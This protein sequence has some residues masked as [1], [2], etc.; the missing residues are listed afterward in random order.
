MK[1]INTSYQVSLSDFRRA[2]YFGLFQRLR[3]PLQIM[4]VVLLVGTL[5]FFGACLGLGQINPLV[6]FITAA[7]L[8][9]GI[10]LFAGTERGVR[11]YLSSKDCLIGCTYQV[12]LESNRIRV[13]VPQRNI[14]FATQVNKLTCV[15]ETS[16]A[17]L[18]Y[19]S[20][21]DVHIL[22]HQALTPEERADLRTNFR[23]HLDGN[24]STRFS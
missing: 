4:V 24:F 23:K 1:K 16:S 22:P 19:T 12:E 3:R 9:W 15:F 14:S 17:F 13:E 11:R 2:T 10:I 7:Y 5:Y 20:L 6:L 18:I 21:Q 8:I